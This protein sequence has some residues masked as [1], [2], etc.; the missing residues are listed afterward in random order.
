M[1][2]N[3]FDFH[4]VTSICFKYSHLPPVIPFIHTRTT[5][6]SSE[7]AAYILYWP[8]VDGHDVHRT[9]MTT[10]TKPLGPFRFRIKMM[11]ASLIVL[12]SILISTSVHKTDTDVSNNPSSSSFGGTHPQP[13]KST[14]WNISRLAGDPMQ[15]IRT[16]ICTNQTKR[17]QIY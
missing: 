9:T 5:V 3:I 8:S 7:T 1:D 6:R 2:E 4:A 16:T 12:Y 17:R 14:E 15:P 13:L 11:V 10:V